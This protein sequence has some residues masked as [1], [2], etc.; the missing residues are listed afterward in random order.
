MFPNSMERRGDRSPSM[1]TA[2]ND[3]FMREM[4]PRL[5]RDLRA[6]VQSDL[7]AV[8][9]RNARI[10]PQQIVNEEGSPRNR[11]NIADMGSFFDP[12]RLL[13][14]GSR[15]LPT[16]IN[17][18]DIAAAIRS[19]RLQT[20]SGMGLVFVMDRLVK[21]QE[22]SCMYVVFFDIASRAIISQ[23]RVCT[24]AGGA[25]IRNH[26]F[27]SIKETVKRLPEMYQDAKI[28]R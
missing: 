5:G 27:G 19:Y 14:R 12:M 17:D 22:T 18:A 21:K 15:D 4:Y 1:T 9:L 16:H 26:W 7:R 6:I 28:K 24:D 10:S 3:L 8:E 20:R 11:P 2:W 23:E 13:H 25:G